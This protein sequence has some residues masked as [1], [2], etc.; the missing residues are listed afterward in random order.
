ME[1]LKQVFGE[2]SCTTYSWYLSC[3]DTSFNCAV[4]SNGDVDC[5]DNITVHN[6]RV[7]SDNS[8]ICG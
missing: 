8:V 4:N 1:H 5:K 7:N 2:N 6:C 3:Q